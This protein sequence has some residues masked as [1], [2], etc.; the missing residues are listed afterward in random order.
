MVI[1]PLKELYNPNSE[2]SKNRLLGSFLSFECVTKSEDVESFLKEK[3]IWFEERDLSR[4]F[5]VFDETAKEL[6]GYFSLAIKSI[7]IQDV[8]NTVRKKFAGTTETDHSAAYLIGQI[9]KDKKCGKRLVKYQILDEALRYIQR[10]RDFVGGRVVYLDC[11]NQPDLIKYYQDAGF[12]FLRERE[13]GDVQM[14][15]R[16]GSY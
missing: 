14:Y 5:L 11:K 12:A 2:D 6:L 8:S 4:T 3:C 13:D 10:S 9:G 16:I 1:S 7:D 15:M